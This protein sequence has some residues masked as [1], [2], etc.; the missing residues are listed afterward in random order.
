MSSPAPTFLTACIAS[1]PEYPSATSACTAS[2]SAL[3]PCRP[4]GTCFFLLMGKLFLKGIVELEFILQLEDRFLCRLLPDSR[5]L[6]NRRCIIG[7]HGKAKIIRTHDGK[8]TKSAFGADAADIEQTDE[9]LPVV[10]VQKAEER[11]GIL[12]DR[13][14][15]IELDLLPLTNIARQRASRHKHL[16]ADAV[17]VHNNTVFRDLLDHAFDK[18]YHL[19]LQYISKRGN[20]S[21]R[22]PQTDI[23]YYITTFGSTL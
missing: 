12:F 20:R 1:V 18:S 14:I 9:H 10:P 3:R 7:E 13:Q 16:P 6:G 19:C 22:F 11:E 17:V 5:S 8:D 2:V 21:P 23:P 15:G 4:A